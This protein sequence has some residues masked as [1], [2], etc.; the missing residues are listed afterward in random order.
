MIPGLES[1][2]LVEQPLE[3]RI[4]PIHPL[5]SWRPHLLRAAG[6]L[7]ALGISALIIIE[8]DQLSSLG[9]YGYPGVFLISM[10]SSATV[11]LPAPSLAVVFA[12]GG[13]LNPLLVGIAAGFGEALGEL[14][15]YVAGASGRAIIEDRERYQRLVKLTRRY[16]LLIIFFLSMVP[17]PTFDLA[18]I[19][20]GALQFPVSRF[21][22]ACWAGKTI[23]TTI[24]ALLGAGSLGLFVHFL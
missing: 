21:L 15:G 7:L 8:R 24:V 2:H 5:A 17:N 6:L 1:K 12:T 18:G 9:R 23:K 11:F 4:R 19:A 20:A 13:V 10:A 16:G 3:Q 22:M 14:T